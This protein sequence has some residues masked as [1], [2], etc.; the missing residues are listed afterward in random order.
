MG[1]VKKGHGRIQGLV[2]GW[3]PAFSLSHR[4]SSTMKSRDTARTRYRALKTWANELG[5]AP[6]VKLLDAIL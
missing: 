6:A 3:M 5:P 1:L 4:R 2:G